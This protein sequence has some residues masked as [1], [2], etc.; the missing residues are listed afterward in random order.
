MTRAEKYPAI[1]VFMAFLALLAASC[2]TP[3]A[4]PPR[5]L[6]GMNTV[7]VT[8]FVDMSALHGPG[9]TVRS[10]VT[11]GVFTTGPVA[12][13]VSDELF[14]TLIAQVAALGY[15]VSASDDAEGARSLAVASKKSMSERD[16]ALEM[17]RKS[18]AD[19]V[20]IGC[21][22]R[23]E[24][25]VGANYSAEKAA[26]AAFDAA[27][28]RMADGAVLWSARF[29]EAQKP[30]SDNLLDMSSFLKRRG[31]WVTVS[32]FARDA[33]TKKLEGFPRPIGPAKQ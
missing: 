15:T 4:T 22:Y 21:V 30:L 33:L 26:S 3:A 27:L 8:P 17:G 23:L 12:E 6:P 24:E 18:G 13:G 7:L 25:R 2:A 5:T 11:G 14:R 31:T 32:D 28:I 16:L 29:D 10:P 9:Q 20:I 19:G 1:A